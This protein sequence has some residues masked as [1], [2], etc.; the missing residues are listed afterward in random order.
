MPHF[1]AFGTVCQPPSVRLRRYRIRMEPNVK[2]TFA[3]N[4][5]AALAKRAGQS[6]LGLRTARSILRR[7]LKFAP[8]PAERLLDDTSDVQ[9]S[10]AN[11]AAERLGLRLCDLLKPDLK[12]DLQPR[13]PVTLKE[14]L[15]VVLD[16]VQSTSDRGRLRT[17][18]LALIDADE[19][20]YRAAVERLLSSRNEWDGSAESDRRRNTG[21][22]AEDKKGATSV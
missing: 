22:R 13:Q 15:P 20:E 3:R 7:E 8:G 10:T 17:A 4:L 18:M 14:A 1:T 6:E 12:V 5:L 21:R 16:A 2:K 11:E 9:I 19:P